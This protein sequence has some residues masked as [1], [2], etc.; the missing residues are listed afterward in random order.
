M[1]KIIQTTISITIVYS[2]SNLIKRLR[3]VKLSLLQRKYIH[4]QICMLFSIY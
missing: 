3:I 1:N 2:L 4:I